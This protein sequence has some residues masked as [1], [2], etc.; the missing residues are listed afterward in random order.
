MSDWQSGYLE[1]SAGREE[2]WEEAPDEVLTVE[3][4]RL[5]LA[6]RRANGEYQIHH[7]PTGRIWAGPTERVGSLT[8]GPND[9]RCP[10]GYDG[11]RWVSSLD[12]P[13]SAEIR[14][15][16]V[17]L[18]FVP[19]MQGSRRPLTLEVTLALVSDDDLEWSYRTYD[20]DGAWSVHSVKLIDDALTIDGPEDYAVVPVYQ[21]EVV[22]VGS[23]FSYLPEDRT[24]STRTSDAVGTYTGVSSW[25]MAMF[26]LVKGASTAVIT[27]ADPSVEAG[28]V[29][30]RDPAE[31]GG[32]QI[33]SRVNLRRAARSVRLH[34]MEDAGYVEVAQYYRQVAKTRGFFDTFRDK[35]RRAPDLEKNVGAVRFT[36]FPKWGRGR[37]SGWARFLETD[38]SRI[39]YTFDEVADV[40][41]HFVNDLGI[42]KGLTIVTAWTRRGYDMDYPDVL[43]AAEECGGNEGLARASERVRRLGWQFGLHDN[44]LLQFKE[45]PSTDEANALMRIDGTPVEGGV[46]FNGAWELYQCCP[47]RMNITVTRNFQ[48]YNE[49]FNLNCVYTDMIA[50]MPILECFSPEHPLTHQQT[51]DTFAELVAYQRTQVG[52]MFSEI[53]DE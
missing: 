30:G 17:V 19:T 7:K 44:S 53:A 50:A 24:I 38:Q 3:S 35:I 26:A 6:V 27:W 37:A 51:I 52:V 20:E 16:S 43:P 1:H 12:H 18:T 21:G 34:F 11:D 25:S 33:R 23:S 10:S 29:G 32:W 36:V 14:E 48:Q 41:E 9:G 49:L 31:D 15:D 45:C 22:P 28:V 47:A 46:G 42:K 40:N 5:R 2:L 4:E 13:Q 39:D 8:L